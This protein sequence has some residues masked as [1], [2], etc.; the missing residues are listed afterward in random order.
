M[1]NY[2]FFATCPRHLESLLLTELSALG[3]H[4]LR[5]TVAGVYFEGDLP[6]VYRVCLWSRL[7][8]KILLPLTKFAV[9][10]ADHIYDAARQVD[11]Q[12]HLK[13]TGSLIVDFTG[14]DEQV[15]HT[16]FGAQRVKDGIVDNLRDSTGDRPNVDR[17]HPDYRINAHLYKQQL[18]VSLVKTA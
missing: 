17:L 11:W 4:T 9:T 1:S 10:H 3:A 5:E 14:T 7:A 6:L 12:A 13:P 15:R 8:N 2:Q 18:I 16:Q